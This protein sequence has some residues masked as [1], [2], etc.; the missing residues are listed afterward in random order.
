MDEALNLTLFQ[1]RAVT[2][3]CCC[4]LHADLYL[5]SSFWLLLSWLCRGQV[6]YTSP[7]HDRGVS[8]RENPWIQLKVL[9]GLGVHGNTPRVNPCD[10]NAVLGAFP[11]CRRP[12]TLLM[13]K[14]SNLLLNLESHAAN[15]PNLMPPPLSL[16]LRTRKCWV[17]LS[18]LPLFPFPHAHSRS[19]E[20]LAQA[21]TF[22]V[23]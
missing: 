9:K 23:T 10:T 21:L 17:L 4:F 14:P 8:A 7:L 18:C 22:F 1:W 15:T 16:P 5:Y 6:G 3:Q 19:S 12:A 2:T 11:G 20:G 13:S